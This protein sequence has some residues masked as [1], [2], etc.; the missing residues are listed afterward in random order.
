MITTHLLVQNDKN[1]ITTALQSVKSLGPIIIGNL[2]STDGSIYICQQHDV[3]IYDI[4]NRNILTEKSTTD[5]NF[6]IHPWEILA[7][8]H[9][10]MIEKTNSSS[11]Y[12]QIFQNDSI[13][14]EI[15]LWN[16]KSNIK[17]HNPVFESL[18]DPKAEFL[19]SAFLYSKKHSVDYEKQLKDI[20]TWK[21]KQPTLAEP[22]YY[23][24]CV[25]LNQGK[26]KEFLF[27]A[28]S[29]LFRKQ[30]GIATVMLKYYTAL[31]YLHFKDLNK[32]IFHIMGCIAVRPLMAEY[33]CLLGDIHY[34]AHEYKKALA[35]YENAI[36]LG[37]KRP[38]LDEWP[39]E[40]SKYQDYPEKMIQSC[41]TMLKD[42]KDYGS[43]TSLV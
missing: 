42:S 10:E 26:Y 19:E 15:R 21:K 43:K 3:E 2:G 18:A 36:I 5:W 33:W 6:F 35:F 23:Q 17:F 27:T 31:I 8:G 32:A 11:F 4:T 34:Q 28:D 1:T 41:R 16:K 12:I 13:S 30:S 25:L 20:E 37:R 38:R 7:S 40:I 29:Y 39:V 24:A 14:K 22:Y 9:Q